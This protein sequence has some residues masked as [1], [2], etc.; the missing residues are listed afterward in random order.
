[1]RLVY[2]VTNGFGAPWSYDYE[3]GQWQ[4]ESSSATVI[5]PDGERWNVVTVESAREDYGCVVPA[6]AVRP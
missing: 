6:K 4:Q 2:I 3:A 1:M 5:E